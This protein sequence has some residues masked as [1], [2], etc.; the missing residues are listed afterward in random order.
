MMAAV[1]ALALS[2]TSS[3]AGT[4]GNEILKSNIPQIYGKSKDIFQGKDGKTIIHIQD[5]HGNVESQENIQ[6]IIKTLSEQGKIDAIMDEGG[7][8]EYDL[9]QM[10]G[11]SQED[12]KILA[13]W[14]TK[15]GLTHGATRYKFLDNPKMS[16]F[17]SEDK[18]TYI[19]GL[20]A[21]RESGKARDESLAVTEKIKGAMEAVKLKLFDAD[22][23]NF[24][25][26]IEDFKED[27]ITLTTYATA[28]KAQ[29]EKA[30]VNFA[31]YNNFSKVVESIALEEKVDFAKIDRERLDMVDELE[32]KVD[33]KAAD[34]I[35]T[36]SL[37]YRLGKVAASDYYKFLLE[38]AGSVKLDL[39]K[40][41]NVTQYSSLVSLYASIND[42]ALFAETD[43]LEGEIKSKLFKE[44]KQL[45]FD[46][47]FKNLDILNK[48]ISLQM[49]RT[50]LTFWKENKDKISMAKTVAF[51]KDQSKAL[52][53]SIELQDSLS[54][55]DQ[56]VASNE[57]FYEL[58]LRRDDIMIEKTLAMMDE[59]GF[60]TVVLVAGGF[61]SEGIVKAL[62]AKAIS[63]MIVTPRITNPDAENFWRQNM[64]GEETEAAK[65]LAKA[66]IKTNIFTQATEEEL[67]NANQ[68]LL[69]NIKAVEA[70]ALTKK[71]QEDISGQFETLLSGA[72]LTTDRETLSPEEQANFDAIKALYAVEGF[73]NVIYYEVGNQK[74]SQF[75][76]L[77]NGVKAP[78]LRKGKTIMLPRARLGLGLG[79]VKLLDGLLA[80]SEGEEVREKAIGQ[81][82]T[83]TVNLEKNSPKLQLLLAVLDQSEGLPVAVI[84]PKID[85]VNNIFKEDGVTLNEA[86]LKLLNIPTNGEIKNFL[87][88]YPNRAT[89]PR[90]YVTFIENLGLLLSNTFD[91]IAY[92]Q[93]V[94]NALI[95]LGDQSLDNT[96]S[97]I[98]IDKGQFTT[99]SPGETV[100][101]RN[102]F[103]QNPK[104]LNDD[105]GGRIFVMPKAEVDDPEILAAK[106]L[107]LLQNPGAKVEVRTM[108][109]TPALELIKLRKENVH[110]I[111]IGGDEA[112][113]EQFFA[114]NKQDVHYL[115]QE[116]SAKPNF[117]K[118]IIEYDGIR[119]FNFA[120]AVSTKLHLKDNKAAFD[121]ILAENNHE[122]QTATRKKEISNALE[123]F[124]NKGASL[125]LQ[126][127]TPTIGA[128][129]Q[130]LAAS[131]NVSWNA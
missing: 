100:G 84:Q 112:D 41:S 123:S 12:K 39:S 106:N 77:L 115:V 119:G 124:I 6:S 68:T 27:K 8:N 34:E 60:K 121:V 23:R 32:S 40:Y 22:T 71:G 131:Q 102:A 122:N 126:N 16:I 127:L 105:K 25:Q 82:N 53:L 36:Q 118:G 15:Y 44:Q 61:H 78:S 49:T 104:G 80:R 14:Y 114:D 21:F 3:Y 99:V 38:K 64:M 67:P 69:A 113:I 89:S 93:T 5:A 87:E 56:K 2:G 57:K 24:L 7:W 59:K 91:N 45:D 20:N 28:L 43:R 116:L 79:Y 86:V 37:N 66:G 117:N 81:D 29:A 90:T 94:K 1:L 101:A 30:G 48:L 120:L 111:L 128:L 54:Q 13:D 72:I 65:Q 88:S 10:E 63:H 46:L 4:T 42:D 74:G 18:S 17:G 103:L 96:V 107:I 108:Q 9:S 26:S 55:I 83:F 62:K 98:V 51:L 58:A 130:A 109:N 50:D 11:F 52:G 110:V 129:L 19:D 70:G 31:G 95:N 92:S 76:S 125:Q 97:A 47:H 35:V 85:I 75:F 33:K 73:E